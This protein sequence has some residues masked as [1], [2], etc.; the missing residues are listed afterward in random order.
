MPFGKYFLAALSSFYH[1]FRSNDS[2]VKSVRHDGSY[3]KSFAEV[4]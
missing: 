2:D 3:A 1:S 4:K